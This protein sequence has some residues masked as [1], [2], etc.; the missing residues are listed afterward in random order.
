VKY[1]PLAYRDFLTL[2]RER[3]R[4]SQQQIADALHISRSAWQKYEYGV[5]RPKREHREAILQLLG[6]PLDAWGEDQICA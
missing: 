1:K 5:R 2:A 6:V 3:S 4:L